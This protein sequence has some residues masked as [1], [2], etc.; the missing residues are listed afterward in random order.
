VWR[1]HERYARDRDP[2]ALDRLV[3]EYGRYARSLAERMHRGHESI[4]DLEQ[5]AMEALVVALRRFE[6]E[7]GLP[8]PALATPTILGALRRHYRDQGW[9]VRVPRRV[10]EL[11]TALRDATAHLTVVLGRAPTVAELARHLDVAVDT[12][13]EAQEALHARD[14]RSIDASFG[15][16]RRLVDDLGGDDPGLSAAEDRLAAADAIGTLGARDRELLRLYFVEERTQS[17]VAEVL[18]VSQMQ[19]SRLLSSVLRRLRQRVA[20]REGPAGR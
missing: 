11:A 1:D 2:A 18:G 17:E 20:P 5:I 13:L 3:R 14:T 12:V 15:D 19:V 8:F 10:H 4:E 6:P 9:L 7:R 16:D